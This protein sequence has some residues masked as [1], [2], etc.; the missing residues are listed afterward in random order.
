M[1]SVFIKLAGYRPATL[2]KLNFF[3]SIFQRFVSYNQL[4]T[5]QNRYFEEYLFLQNDVLK[6]LLLFMH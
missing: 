5:L 1:C 4:D 2:L 6:W 3:T